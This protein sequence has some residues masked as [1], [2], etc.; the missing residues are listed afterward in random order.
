[1]L[2]LLQPGWFMANGWEL[3]AQWRQHDCIINIHFQRK[4]YFWSIAIPHS[5]D[6]KPMETFSTFFLNCFCA[7]FVLPFISMT[8]Q[9]QHRKNC[10]KCL[11]SKQHRYAQKSCCSTQNVVPRF[12]TAPWKCCQFLHLTK[13]RRNTN[14]SWF[15]HY[16]QTICY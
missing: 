12:N 8:K 1:M 10:K 16:P 9:G 13:R 7:F 6:S 5:Q 15:R 14:M 3:K 4:I 11:T 2:G